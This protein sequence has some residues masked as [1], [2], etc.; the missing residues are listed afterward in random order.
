M[1]DELTESKQTESTTSV[2]VDEALA[3]SLHIRT[4]IT[5][6]YEQIPCNVKST[7]LSGKI[8]NMWELA[9]CCENT[10]NLEWNWSHNVHRTSIPQ[11]TWMNSVDPWSVEWIKGLANNTNN[12]CTLKH[13]WSFVHESCIAEVTPMLIRRIKELPTAEALLSIQEL[14]QKLQFVWWKWSDNSLEVKAVVASNNSPGGFRLQWFGHSRNLCKGKQTPNSWYTHP[15]PSLQH[16]QDHEQRRVYFQIHNSRINL[17]QTLWMT[18][19][20]CHLSLY[21]C[22]VPRLQLVKNA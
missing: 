15:H 10:Q 18:P 2:E 4:L 19:P 14:Q 5:D 8:Y 1:I 6:G 22:H 9:S 21:P 3:E 13:L 7:P 11:M 16:Q 12:N 17:Q 20:S